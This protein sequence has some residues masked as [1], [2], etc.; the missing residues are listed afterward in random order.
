MKSAARPRPRAVVRRRKPSVAA[1][2]RPFWILAVL[3]LLAQLP[4]PWPAVAAFGRLIP[5]ALLD[6]AYRLIA[7]YRYRIWGRLDAC[8]IPTA[9]ERSRFL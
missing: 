5:P 8:P 4:A 7:H 6:L 9:E 1:R 2:V 3:V